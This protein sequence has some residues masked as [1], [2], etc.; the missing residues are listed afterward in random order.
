MLGRIE[1][2]FG[3][4]NYLVIWSL[5]VE[6]SLNKYRHKLVN[7]SSVGSYVFVYNC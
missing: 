7:F 2:V 6:A 4:R 1:Q 5:I 3:T